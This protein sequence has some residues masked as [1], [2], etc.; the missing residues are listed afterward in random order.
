MP[1]KILKQLI[2]APTGSDPSW[3][4]R[5]VYVEKLTTDDTIYTF[6]T[7]SEANTKRDELIAADSTNRI[8][9]VIEL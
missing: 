8:Y 2:P 4:Q 5:N 7:E 6:D 9:K 3:A 1:F